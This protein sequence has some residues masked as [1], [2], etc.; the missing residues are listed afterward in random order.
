[1]QTS[2]NIIRTKYLSIIRRI[3]FRDLEYMQALTLC[4]NL[5]LLLKSYSERVEIW[6]VFVLL[7]YTSKVS[8]KRVHFAQKH[9]QFGYTFGLGWFF[10]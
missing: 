6:Q 4:F 3:Y 10:V 8:M 9:H 1:M 5:N 7:F 2:L